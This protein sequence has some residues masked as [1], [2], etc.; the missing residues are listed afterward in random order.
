MPRLHILLLAAIAVTARA[1]A[2]DHSTMDHSRMH[3]GAATST[4]AMPGQD[5]YAAIAEV[6][7]LLQADSTTDWSKVNVEAL[8]QHL[9]DM[10]L[11][12][13]RSAVR[14]TTVPS[15]LQMLV[16]GDARTQEAIRRMTTSHAAALRPL[17]LV[18]VSE[19]VPGGAKFTVTVAD[20][21]DTRLLAQVRGLG[22]AGLMTLGDHHAPHHLAIARGASGHGH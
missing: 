20:S 17:G 10:N 2:Q 13:L 12:T 15:G 6:V 11:V 21:G 1:Q 19:P 8:R 14:Q 18:A 7:R 16:T 3:A 22:F 4:P 9:I 5:A